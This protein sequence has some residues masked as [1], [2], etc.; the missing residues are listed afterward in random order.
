MLASFL[1]SIM[2]R[3]QY[4][5]SQLLRSIV[6]QFKTTAYWPE[7]LSPLRQ[8]PSRGATNAAFLQQAFIKHTDSF[9]GFLL[10]FQNFYDFAVFDAHAC[11]LHTCMCL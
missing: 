7:S 6:Y 10:L 9:W 11:I 2:S 4:V 1:S 8:E 3:H 5:I